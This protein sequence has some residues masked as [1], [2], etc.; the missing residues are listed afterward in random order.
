MTDSMFPNDLTVIRPDQRVPGPNSPGQD[1]ETA[2]SNPGLW[3]GYCDITARNEPGA[4]HHHSNYDSVMYLLSGRC[5]IDYGSNGEKSYVMSKGDFGFFGQGVIH[6]VQILDDG[7]C[8]Y[9]FIRLGEGESVSVADAPAP[10]IR[11]G[12]KSEMFPDDLV[13]VA[14]SE[15][16]PAATKG[17]QALEEAFNTT[18]LRVSYGQVTARGEAGDMA[19]S[20]WLRHRDQRAVRQV[21]ARLRFGW[22]EVLRVGGRR[23]RPGGQGRRPPAAS[24]G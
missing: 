12:K 4:W 18:G 17:G 9:I 19:S 11:T 10:R 14:P 6:R 13:F 8:D 3:V 22:R 23:L 20:W 15:R 16:E 2:F 24:P 7:K 5:R 1:R 21:P